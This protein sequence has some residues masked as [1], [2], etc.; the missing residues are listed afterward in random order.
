MARETDAEKGVTF[1]EFLERVAPG[2]RTKIADFVAI[3]HYGGMESTPDGYQVVL[4]EI[5][6]HC[7]HCGGIRS[8]K[9]QTTVLD[10]DRLF[11]E[12]IVS[13]DCKNCIFEFKY[14]ALRLHLDKEDALHEYMKDAVCKTG[15]AFKYGE[16][17]AF[18]PPLP[19]QLVTLVR[20][21]RELFVK[22]RRCE[23]QGLGIAAFAYYRRVIED[24]KGSLIQAIREACSR[25]NADSLLIAEL[26]EAKNETQFDKAVSV[27]KHALPDGLLVSGHNPLTLLHNA[28]SAGL[29]AHSDEECLEL[30]T[31][32]RLVMIDFAERLAAFRKSQSDLDSAVMKLVQKKSE[33]A[34]RASNLKQ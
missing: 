28:L 26:T 34:P 30:A 9:P 29:H 32:I 17:P 25:A 11:Y 24:Q 12:G 31:G 33:T 22:G 1:R 10:A 7:E 8:F 21:Q 19:S 5:E 23:N 16:D 4:P 15:K 18:G 2:A 20:P 14:Y 3:P 6:L 27:I 13:Y